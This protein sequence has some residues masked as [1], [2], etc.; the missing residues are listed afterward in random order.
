MQNYNFVNDKHDAWPPIFILRLAKK[1]LLMRVYYKEN[2][3]NTT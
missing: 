2:W 1:P 3:I